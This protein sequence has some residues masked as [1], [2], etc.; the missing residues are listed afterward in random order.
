MNRFF[1]I[2]SISVLALSACS[3]PQRTE[4]PAPVVR[5]SA[6]QPPPVEAPKPKPEPATPKVQPVQVYAYQHPGEVP[7]LPPDE[8]DPRS[9]ATD[10]AAQGQANP[11]VSDAGAGTTGSAPGAAGQAAPKSPETKP[12]APSEPPKQP[13]PPQQAPPP[14]RVAA[15]PPPPASSAATTLSPATQALAQQAEQ[16]RQMGDYAGAAATIERGLRISPQEAYL[17]NRL[18]RVRLEQGLHS[19][20][21]NLAARSNS[22]AGDQPTLK[23]DN[24][25]IIADAKRQAGDVKGAQEAELKAR[26]S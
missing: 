9:A 3:M 13:Q 11:A 2:I 10:G 25:R 16:Q 4:P 6:P 12:P 14:Q 8:G 15:A 17:W 1:L 26:G 22:L 5:V 24:W 20:A 7:S 18:A 19:Q 21:G 23:Q